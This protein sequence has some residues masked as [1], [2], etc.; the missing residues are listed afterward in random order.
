MTERVL[1]RQVRDAREEQLY[2]QWAELDTLYR[3]SPLSMALIR[4]SDLVIQRINEHNA[5]LL[6]GEAEDLIGHC[7]EEFYPEQPFVGEV[8]RKVIA[9]R[10]ARTLEITS[11]APSAPGSLL[12]W[13]WNL[14][15]IL[16]ATGTV[17]SIAST[18]LEITQPTG[19]L[20]V[21]LDITQATGDVEVFVDVEN[22]LF[23]R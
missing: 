1:D 21:F 17:E 14:N 16:D 18:V 12:R 8:L 3:T 10:T 15:P 11:E 7:I 19:D 22:E 13:H 9:D 23:G 6:G 4:A 2:R 20:E 5:A